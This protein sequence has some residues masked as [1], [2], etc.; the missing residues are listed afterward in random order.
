MVVVTFDHI[1]RQTSTAFIIPSSPLRVEAKKQAM[2]LA[3]LARGGCLRTRGGGGR[4][5]P[6]GGSRSWFL[7]GGLCFFFCA[8][9]CWRFSQL[10]PLW[11]LV[12]CVCVF[13]FVLFFCWLLLEV[14]AAG[15]LLGGCWC[16]FSFLFFLWWFCWFFFGG[17]SC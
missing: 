4:K 1:Q 12:V 8:G 16:V 9:S 5:G 13:C 3:V 6:A 15:S 7:L 2:G 17:S 14:L 11:W 10:V